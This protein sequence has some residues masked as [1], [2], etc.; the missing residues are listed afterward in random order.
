MILCDRHRL[1]G[2][3]YTLRL[4][5]R[6][7]GVITELP[8]RRCCYNCRLEARKAWRKPLVGVKFYYGRGSRPRSIPW[9]EALLH[10]ALNE[11]AA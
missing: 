4:A 6:R 8:A 11:R 10:K 1:Q 2:S 5:I 9:L 7:A 3:R